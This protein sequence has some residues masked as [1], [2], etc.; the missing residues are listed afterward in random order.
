MFRHLL[1]L[2][3]LLAFSLQSFAAVNS[4]SM[5]LKHHN[6]TS[7]HTSDHPVDSHNSTHQLSSNEGH[8]DHSTNTS[9][10]GCPICAECCIGFLALPT[11]PSVTTSFN[12]ISSI[13][14]FYNVYLPVV[15]LENPIRPPRF[16]YL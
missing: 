15:F 10:K 5:H 9:H 2:I 6:P 13:D 1:I 12:R 8:C 4:L 16:N 14:T 11:I 7:S 3:S